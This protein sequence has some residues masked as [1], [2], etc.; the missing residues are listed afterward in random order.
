MNL[1]VFKTFEF[2]QEFCER[3][4]QRVNMRRVGMEVGRSADDVFRVGRFENNR[5]ARRQDTL[6]LIQQDVEL[7]ET[8]MLDHMERRNGSNAVFFLFGQPDQCILL[9]GLQ[10]LF[11]T[12]LDIH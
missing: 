10:A 12:G 11:V 4:R 2:D 1:D 9:H 3:R 6:A 5:A 7:L 8:Q